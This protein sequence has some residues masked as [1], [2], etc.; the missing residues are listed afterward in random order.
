MYAPG[1][2]VIVEV[3]DSEPDTSR[4]AYW[5]DQDATRP[6]M[7][8]DVYHSVQIAVTLVGHPVPVPVR[9]LRPI[10]TAEYVLELC[11]RALAA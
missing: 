1:D 10:T 5:R 2:L 6:Q 3:P 7:V 8:E 11:R 4:I 9:W